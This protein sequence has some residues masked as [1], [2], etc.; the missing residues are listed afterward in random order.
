MILMFVSSSLLSFL[1]EY[2]I[3]LLLIWL[4]KS[5][6]QASSILFSTAVSRVVS[7]IFNYMYNKKLVF[8][9]ANKTSFLRYT[10]L[11]LFIFGC[12][13]GL[14]YLFTVICG[15]PEWI[16]YAIVQLIVYPMS[17]VLQR[18][19]VFVKDKKLS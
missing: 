15:I 14:L 7:S 16:S 9:T 12:H 1:L 13:Y 19:Y 3:F 11:V 2:I 17:F 8:E 4:T 10:V 5:W 18:K 6:A